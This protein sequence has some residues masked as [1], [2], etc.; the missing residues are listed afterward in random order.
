MPSLQRVDAAKPK[1]RR[2]V[3]PIV[4][5]PFQPVATHGN[6]RSAS[7][8]AAS[9]RGVEDVDGTEFRIRQP[10]ERTVLRTSLAAQVSEHVTS[11]KKA[12]NDNG[13]NVADVSERGGCGGPA[14]APSSDE[15]SN[16]A[17]DSKALGRGGAKPP[18]IS[19]SPATLHNSSTSLGLVGQ[20]AKDKNIVPAELHMGHEALNRPVGGPPSDAERTA[21]TGVAEGALRTESLA[22]RHARRALGNRKEDGQSRPQLKSPPELMTKNQNVPRS[23]AAADSRPLESTSPL[24]SRWATPSVASVKSPPSPYL[25]RLQSNLANPESWIDALKKQTSPA[26]RPNEVGSRNDLQK[27]NSNVCTSAKGGVAISNLEESY[28]FKTAPKPNPNRSV[29]NESGSTKSPRHTEL[30]NRGGDEKRGLQREPPAL[31]RDECSP[32]K[33]SASEQADDED[34]CPAIRNNAGSSQSQGSSKRSCGANEDKASTGADADAERVKSES[35]KLAEERRKSEAKYQ[36]DLDRAIAAS[37][38]Q[39]QPR[40][41]RNPSAASEII[42][43]PDSDDEDD[44]KMPAIQPERQPSAAVTA[45][46]ASSNQIKDNQMDENAQIEMAIKLSM[47]E[48]EKMK[49]YQ[50]CGSTLHTC[51]KLNRNEFEE[52]VEDFVSQQGGFEKIE[53]GQLVKHGNANDMKKSCIAAGGGR[54]QTGAQYGRYSINS[55]WRLFDVLEGKA[56]VNLEKSGVAVKDDCKKL[57]KRGREKNCR[58]DGLPGAKIKAFLDIG[59]GLGKRWYVMLKS[60][61]FVCPPG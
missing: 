9:G 2:P 20:Y 23:S 6:G 25:S 35:K 32:L 40:S 4:H 13:Q 55:M 11:E 36:A 43:L 34:D 52:I 53:A 19:P 17:A 30:S 22:Q 1:R 61:W 28:F 42:E 59:H 51:R 29:P 15:N 57:S 56:Y 18:A 27:H 31:K 16:P 48:A 33:Q 37:M 49:E 54:N 26:P 58:L 7:V 10:E 12:N 24:K 39:Q 46:A 50:Q 47:A 8:S 45:M 3:G 44:S 60:F 38:R 5:R 21:R 41:R 14:S